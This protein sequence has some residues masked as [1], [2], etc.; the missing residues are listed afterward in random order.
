MDQEKKQPDNTPN[1]PPA[2]VSKPSGPDAFG[3]P[4]LEFKPIQRKEEN[5]VPKSLAS[6]PVAATSSKATPQSTKTPIKPPANPS[7]PSKSKET[8]TTPKRKIKPLVWLLM[9]LVLVL[10]GLGIFIYTSNKQIRE[11]WMAIFRKSAERAS[12]SGTQESIPP[13]TEEEM[14]VTPMEEQPAS[15]SETP[16]G[17]RYYIIVGGFAVPDN[18]K[19]YK[20]TLEKDGYAAKVLDPAEGKP[21]YKVSVQDF[22]TIVEALAAREELKQKF[23]LTI[24]VYKK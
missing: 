19:R 14:M 17:V 1:T 12:E 3:I 13:P 2:K 8:T 7:A 22:A 16:S 4:D 21:L 9:L 23:D 15:A 11:D 6:Q 24:W 10:S 20:E 5:P 18:A